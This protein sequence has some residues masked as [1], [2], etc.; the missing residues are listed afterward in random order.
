MKRVLE[1]NLSSSPVV[2]EGGD[3][4]TTAASTTTT[5]VN[6]ERLLFVLVPR[7]YVNVR[8]TLGLPVDEEIDDCMTIYTYTV[9]SADAKLN[10][11]ER[12][13]EMLE[14]HCPSQS[15]PDCIG[16]VDMTTLPI[17]L[18]FLSKSDFL[19]RLPRELTHDS[20]GVEEYK[21]SFGTATRADFGKWKSSYLDGGDTFATKKLYKAV[22]FINYDPV[23]V[24]NVI[25]HEKLEE[26][27]DV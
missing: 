17:L 25:E 27:E 8:K 12:L 4:A 11:E 24:D 16:D 15:H 26:E 23:V 6:Q 5:G 19:V 21:T 13:L 20:D 14:A 18:M 9:G 2:N 10:L 1:S 7:A 22:Y 3:K